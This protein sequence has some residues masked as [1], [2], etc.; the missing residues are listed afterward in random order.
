MRIIFAKF[1][2]LSKI[3][4]L[5]HKLL[6]KLP[7]HHHCNWHAQKPSCRDFQVIL[8]SS[9]RSKTTL[10]ILK[11]KYGFQIFCFKK[12]VESALVPELKKLKT[13]S[14]KLKMVYWKLKTVYWKL[15]MYSWK[16]PVLF[17]YGKVRDNDVFNKDQFHLGKAKGRGKRGVWAESL[18]EGYF[19][20][21]PITKQDTNFISQI[22]SQTSN[23]HH[24]KWHAQKPTCRD[25]QVILSSSSWSK[26]TFF[27]YF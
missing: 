8:N 20:K 14:W 17:P 23:Q 2:L 15:K 19:C 24:C 12:I 16:T 7:N 5:S 11:N 21:I 26:T 1:L 13:C 22:F 9:S 3:Q 18:N 25:F 10:Y 27:V 4:T 6:V